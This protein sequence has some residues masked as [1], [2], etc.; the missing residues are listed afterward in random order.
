MFVPATADTKDKLQFYHMIEQHKTFLSP[1]S[2][3]CV[4]GLHPEV[5]GSSVHDELMNP[6]QS[7]IMQLL[8]RP[9]K[10]N[11]AIMLI[12]QQ[13]ELGKYIMLA[14]TRSITNALLYALHII[15]TYGSKTEA[16][17]HHRK[18][19]PGFKDIRSN[20]AIRSSG[21]AEPNEQIPR[22]TIPASSIPISRHDIT[23]WDLPHEKTTD[24]T[25]WILPF[26]DPQ[27]QRS[28]K[29]S[30]RDVNISEW[31]TPIST[32]SPFAQHQES[33]R[34]RKNEVLASKQRVINLL[35]QSPEREQDPNPYWNSQAVAPLK[36]APPAR[37]EAPPD[38][39]QSHQN[40]WSKTQHS[41]NNSKPPGI[42]HQKQ[43]PNQ[44]QHYKPHGE[45]YEDRKPEPQVKRPDANPPPDQNKN[46]STSQPENRVSWTKPIAQAAYKVHRLPHQQTR[47]L[48]QKQYQSNRT[49]IPPRNQHTHEQHRDYP[50]RAPPSIQP[51]PRPPPVFTPA[52]KPPQPQPKDPPMPT[53]TPIHTP[54]TT[55]ADKS[56]TT[57]ISQNSSLTDS[58]YSSLKR[59][60]DLLQ[61]ELT[62]LK[63]V[64]R[65]SDERILAQAKEIESLNKRLTQ[66][67]EE[68]TILQTQITTMRKANDSTLQKLRDAIEDRDN[69]DLQFQELSKKVRQMT[70]PKPK[71][72]Q[73]ADP[74]T[75]HDWKAPP[76][77]QGPM[78]NPSTTTGTDQ[79]LSAPTGPPIKIPETSG[80]HTQPTE[81]TTSLPTSRD[82]GKQKQPSL[83]RKQSKLTY[84]KKEPRE[85]ATIHQKPH[86]K[87][88]PKAPAAPPITVANKTR[89][90]TKLKRAPPTRTRY[91]T[92]LSPT[93]THSLS[94]T[95]SPTQNQTPDTDDDDEQITFDDTPPTRQTKRRKT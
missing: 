34:T 7:T 4:E 63:N 15:S 39:T 85:E 64:V 79:T 6:P 16:F 44:T 52:P 48:E 77:R 74:D 67:S 92:R 33:E 82:S 80:M 12:E 70:L 8:K 31:D 51:N 57:E 76:N 84:S 26:E 30:L 81:N 94:P 75:P 78:L 14:P 89:N 87:P 46:R 41:E 66:S 5:V 25:D 88:A 73:E 90:A 23:K 68:K 71:Q 29:H 43:P 38:P 69:A 54:T 83:P 17:S 20:I 9:Y 95:D 59:E 50:R 18:N 60:H 55:T 56:Q 45:M 11:D 32:T 91:S 40:T 86:A 36:T 21:P 28:V 35:S 72:L 10:N 53:R 13:G 42:L 65:T 19:T 61:Q 1:L 47:H 27:L 93:Q 58:R 37:W 2:P 24:T 49:P 62:Q 3:F 22:I